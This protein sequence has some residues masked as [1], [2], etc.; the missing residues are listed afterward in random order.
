MKTFDSILRNIEQ[1][2]G[3]SEFFYKIPLLQRKFVW[4]E[5]DVNGLLLDIESTYLDDKKSNY[6]V[7][8]IVL[9]KDPGSRVIVIDGQQRLTTIMLLISAACDQFDLKGDKEHVEL[10]RRRLCKNHLDGK[11]N[12]KK[13]Y[14]LDLQDKDDPTFKKLLRNDKVIKTNNTVSE[15]N[16]ILAKDVCNEFI[17][18]VDDLK[19][20]MR[21]LLHNVYIVRTIAE[22]QSTAFQI[23]ETLN[24]RG[25]RLEPEDLLKNLLLQSIEDKEFDLF[26]EKWHTFTETLMYK[27]KYI[28]RIPTFLKHFIMSKG[29]YVNKSK[30]F[31]WFKDQKYDHDQVLALLDEL[32][33]SS[34]KYREFLD[35]KTNPHIIA[36]KE[37]RF[38]Q[39]YVA[40][41]GCLEFAPSD[42]LTVSKKIEDIAFCYVITST[43]TNELEKKFCKIASKARESNDQTNVIE[44]L[45]ELDKIIAGKEDTVLNSLMTDRF[46]TRSERNKI[47][48]LLRRM[49][50]SL[51]GA[52][53]SSY[54]L[55]HIF[56]EEWGPG[57]KKMSDDDHFDLISR[58]GNLTLLTESDNSSA[59]N[60]SYAEKV[61]IYTNS[62]RL[63][64]SIVAVIKT[65]SKKTKFDKALAAFDYSPTPANWD[66]TE[67]DRRTQSM[68]NLV[69][70]I[71]FT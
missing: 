63:T 28:E 71:L 69:K 4:D 6:F 54:T 48:Y 21:Y 20:Y 66:K 37:L 42:F 13:E 46:N 62:I 67:I 65:G 49:A 68:M 55:E 64:K 27:G 12:I 36:L 14:I 17:E 9:A 57:W 26:A 51:D 31:D 44:V 30:I 32:E 23:F 56:P 11:G 40:L 52:N 16:L 1:I 50:S 61:P 2:F 10:Y 35:G 53:Y 34:R 45:D 39:G 33:S 43:K 25:A 19:A 3:A 22:D 41:L 29:D 24:D 15:N 7:G 18:N 8:G 47:T 5:G 38:K 60:K 59:K 58:F 70:H